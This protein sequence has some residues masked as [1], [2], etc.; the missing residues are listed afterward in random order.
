MYNN[1]SSGD[2]ASRR[3]AEFLQAH[4][5]APHF[6]FPSAGGSLF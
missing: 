3:K 1:Y 4:P 6:A 5:H 2:P